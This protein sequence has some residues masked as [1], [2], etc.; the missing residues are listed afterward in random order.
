MKRKDRYGPWTVYR[1]QI[2]YVVRRKLNY[3]LDW[4]PG[5]IE[6]WDWYFDPEQAEEVAEVLNEC[7]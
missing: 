1:K 5:N 3:K 2:L 7:S 6:E 4:E